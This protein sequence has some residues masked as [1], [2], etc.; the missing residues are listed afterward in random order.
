MEQLRKPFEG[1]RNIIRFNWHF[2]V[3][4]LLLLISG[5]MISGLLAGSGRF[6]VTLVLLFALLAILLSLVV[7]WY[8]Y[9]VSAL[10]QLSWLAA[11]SIKPGDAILN[12]TAGFDETSRLLQNKYAQAEV[13]AFDFYDPRKH[14]EVSIR[15]ARKTAKPFHGTTAIS[16]TH[17]SLPGFYADKIFA[18][19]SAHEIRDREERIRFFTELSRVLKP[20]GQIIVTEHLR[21]AANFLAYNVGFFHFYSKAAWKQTFKAAGL[22]IIR[23]IKITPFISAFILEKYGTAS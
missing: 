6:Y 15:R 18:I 5:F 2:Y 20:G 19:L 12:F 4:S 21:D 14:T 17:L 16:T 3:L 8:V 1:V 10:Y 23:E 11:V 9:D 7:S 22:N 13:S